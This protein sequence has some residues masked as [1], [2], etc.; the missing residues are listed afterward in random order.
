MHKNVLILVV[1]L[2]IGF[3]S[4]GQASAEVTATASTDFVSKYI[5][6]GFNLSDGP[7]IQPECAC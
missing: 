4:L 6:R 1:A 7:N 5:W 3:V 2:A